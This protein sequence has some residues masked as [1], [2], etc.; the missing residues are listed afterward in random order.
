[1]K[2]ADAKILCEK[3][4]SSLLSYELGKAAYIVLPSSE[5]IIISIGTLTAKILTKH[6]TSDWR[7]PEVVVSQDIST[8]EPSLKKHDRLRQ[9]G[10]GAMA[11]DGLVSLVSRCRSLHELRL[12][13]PVL[14]NP[15]EAWAEEKLNMGI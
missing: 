8:W 3:N 5:H 13:W 9:F 15:L 7:F 4:G 12:A 14:R 10:I 2:E 1:M 6:A 11:L